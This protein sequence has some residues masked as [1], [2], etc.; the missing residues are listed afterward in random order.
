MKDNTR[1]VT[2]ALLPAML[3][4]IYNFGVSALLLIFVCVCT[5][6]VCEFL[7]GIIGKKENTLSDGTAVLTGILL[8]LTLPPT[9]PWYLAAAGGAFAILVVKLSFVGIGKNFLNPAL[10]AKVFLL[11]SFAGPMGNFMYQGQS[12]DTPLQM[13][14]SGQSVNTLELFLGTTA[15]TIGGT[16]ALALLLGAAFLVW[17]D[18]IRL[19]IPVSCLIGFVLFYLIFGEPVEGMQFFHYLIAECISGGLFLGIWFM[20]T[21][22]VTSPRRSREQI[23]YGLLI[24]VLAA[25][26]RRFGRNTESIVYAILIGNIATLFIEK[27]FSIKLIRKGEDEGGRKQADGSVKAERNL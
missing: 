5:C 18:V 8:A 20:A 12:C 13:L 22:P 4:G 9:L 21:D 17:M 2:I 14:Q 7:Y 1:L 3:F 26:M 19:E 10:A 15:G 16:S 27:I 23:V 11:L 6:V 25:W 24:G